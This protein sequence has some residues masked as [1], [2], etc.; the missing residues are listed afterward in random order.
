MS[1]GNCNCIKYLHFNTFFPWRWNI[2]GPFGQ[3]LGVAAQYWLS[4]QQYQPGWEQHPAGHSVSL[5]PQYSLVNIRSG[6]EGA[7]RVLNTKKA[8]MIRVLFISSKKT[9]IMNDFFA[10]LTVC[11]CTVY[12]QT[13]NSNLSRIRRGWWFRQS[14][15]VM[16]C[17]FI[18]LFDLFSLSLSSQRSKAL[19]FWIMIVC[20]LILKQ[21]SG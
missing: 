2:I 20:F 5:G 16:I 18:P 14:K 7:A 10:D 9:L 19:H 15:T 13:V 8:K 6:V 4:E 3:S 12:T 1:N 17:A 21:V 11:K